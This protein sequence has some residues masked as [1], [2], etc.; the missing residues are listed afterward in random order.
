MYGKTFPHIQI[1]K[2]LPHKRIIASSGPDH[3]RMLRYPKL[4]LVFAYIM[5]HKIF[6]A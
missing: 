3:V 1:V 6:N 4:A 5:V 2:K